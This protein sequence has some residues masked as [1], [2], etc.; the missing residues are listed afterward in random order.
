[1]NTWR[2]QLARSL[3]ALAL[4]GCMTPP[5]LAQRGV[6]QDR[7]KGRAQGE[8]ARPGGPRAKGEKKQNQGLR[9]MVGLPPKWMERLREMP[10]EEQEGFMA[11]N[12][13]F[14]KLPPER[15]AQIRKRLQQWNSLAPGQRAEVLKREEVWRQMSPEQKRQVREELLPKWEQ[16]T[17]DRRQAI[18]RRLTALRGMNE[19]ERA[20]KL[21]DPAF[22]QGLNPNEQA[23]LRELSKLR[24]GAPPEPSQE[25]P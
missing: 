21:N 4:A 11:N 25:N 24:V 6:G 22:L 16:F 19:S 13:R 3:T 12:E 20:A 9:G 18:L 7:D 10:P 14:Q 5:A 17:P 23:M 2:L 15:Q 8:N 1:M